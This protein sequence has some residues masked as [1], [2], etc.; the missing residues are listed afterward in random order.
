MRILFEVSSEGW[1]ME[2]QVSKRNPFPCSVKDA[3]DAK[4]HLK[5]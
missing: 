5:V 3:S 4:V 2:F 1:R